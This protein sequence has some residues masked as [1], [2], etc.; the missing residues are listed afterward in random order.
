MKINLPSSL[1]KALLSTLVLSS[2]YFTGLQAATITVDTAG[3][4]ALTWTEGSD[5]SITAAAQVSY[6][7]NLTNFRGLSVTASGASLK[8]ANANYIV[9]GAD[10]TLDI[11]EDFT[12]DLG[13]ESTTAEQYGRN[14]SLG[15]HTATFDVAEGKTFSFIGDIVGD[16]GANLNL[17]GG[18]TLQ[19][20]YT[21]TADT[22]YPGTQ[23]DGL[24]LSISNATLDLR[25]ND[26]SQFSNLMLKGN[27]SLNAGATMQLMTGDVSMSNAIS[28]TGT[29][30][31]TG[32]TSLDLTGALTISDTSTLIDFGSTDVDLSAMTLNLNAD[33]VL[34]T[35]YDLFKSSDEITGLTN[36]GFAGFSING[37]D[38]ASHSVIWSYDA[39]TDIYSYMVTGRT[40]STWQGGSGD[41]S[42]G[43]D[44][45]W[46]APVTVTSDL[47]IANAGGTIS[48][49]AAGVSVGNITVTGDEDYTF[50]GGSISMN[51]VLTKQGT[52][53]LSLASTD[54]TGLHGDKN[55]VAGTLAVDNATAL[56]NGKIDIA[57]GA[58]L[59]IAGSL[60]EVTNNISGENRRYG[61]GYT[62]EVGEGTTFTENA[63]LWLA[64][65]EVNITGRGTYK[66]DSILLNQPQTTASTLNIVHNATL[67]ITGQV[68]NINGGVGSFMIGHYGGTHNE[69]NISGKLISHAGLSTNLG[70]ATINIEVDG[71]LELLQGL[72]RVS[73]NNAESTLNVK[74]GGTLILHNSVSG[75]TSMEL[76]INISDKA[77]IEAG[78]KPTGTEFADTTVSAAFNYAEGALVFFIAE[79][80]NQRLILDH[81]V[82][83]GTGEANMAGSGYVSFAGNASMGLINSQGRVE[84]R[85]GVALNV[86]ESIRVGSTYLANA[87][88]AAQIKIEANQGVAAL[89]SSSQISHAKISNASITGVTWMNDVVLTN[90][91]LKSSVLFTEGVNELRDV[92]LAAGADLAVSAN[93]T[94]KLA[95]SSLQYLSSV[96]LDATST[97]VALELTMDSTNTTLTI[98]TMAVT[99][100]TTES[101][102]TGKPAGEMYIYSL[103]NSSFSSLTALNIK[104]DDS[105]T[106]ELGLTGADLDEFNA[107]YASGLVGF[108]LVNVDSLEGWYGNVQIIAGAGEAAIFAKGVTTSANGHLLFYIPEPSTATL[109]LLA[110]TGLL[111]RRR[112]QRV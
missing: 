34:G 68:T 18:G 87:E 65:G 92:T 31:L 111:A 88:D 44:V 9:L 20:T 11:D 10:S 47:I 79:A 67:E 8:A 3:A 45:G 15:T 54:L 101:I 103:N 52:G 12:L 90:S 29:S 32:A 108:E 25:L 71:E 69:I 98:P 105:L 97:L 99:Q 41:L 35:S 55:I 72:D 73:A 49:D 33:Y 37:L 107:R 63:R 104:V 27:V 38:D 36:N 17:Q 30:T 57:S 94:L 13:S 91:E 7:A 89:L 43:S 78:V 23:H 48:V 106:L 96:S 61:S 76:K 74:D 86:T 83:L 64:A 80:Y 70:T 58:T 46:D 5:I 81:E 22:S 93:T 16:S 21:D 28:A 50:N 84:V 39:T 102:A 109:S 2:S 1:R 62:V 60:G 59:Q 66:V 26:A 82:N 75:D 112:R 40:E 14:F 95:G 110:L 100:P 85:D 56:G 42:N 77:T 6:S 4:Q 19:Y 53:T 24:N 51:G